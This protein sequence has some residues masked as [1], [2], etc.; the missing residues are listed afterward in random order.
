[1]DRFK[2]T[3]IAHARRRFLGPYDDAAL[4]ELVP[5]P[6]GSV[7]DVGCGKGAVLAALGGRGIG[8][9]FNPAF[10]AEARTT[11]PE[12]QIWEED[13]RDCLARAP[14]TELIACLGASQAIGSRNEAIL[15]LSDRLLSGG[16]L[17]FGEGYW[18][19]TPDPEY[20][21]FLE[22][23][24]ED[25]TTFEELI[26]SAPG[27]TVLAARE[28]TLEDWDSYEDSYYG[29]VINWCEANRED[30]NAERF[31]DRITRWRDAYLRWGRHT[32]GFGIVHWRKG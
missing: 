24:E 5:D 28:S 21:A 23:K 16:S 18:R 31:H 22:A 20:L 25:M 8:I 30:E 15:A 7:L 9:E 1:L 12:A 32:L 3:T 19:A 17:L 26:S 6:P 27:L 10:A 2:F 29:S 14:E 13:A 4:K 11:N